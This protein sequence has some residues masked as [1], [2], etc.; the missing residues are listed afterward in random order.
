MSPNPTELASVEIR[1]LHYDRIHLKCRVTWCES[2]RA[3]ETSSVG[4]LD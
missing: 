3:T 1:L 2:P 4:S